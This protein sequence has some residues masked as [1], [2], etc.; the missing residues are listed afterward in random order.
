MVFGMNGTAQVFI[1]R[2]MAESQWI[3]RD[4][5][6]PNLGPHPVICRTDPQIVID[7]RYPGEISTA[8]PEEPIKG[9]VLGFSPAWITDEP[10]SWD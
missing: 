5:T 2:E 9:T 1:R 3:T 6:L 4:G 8:P 10:Q 7:Y